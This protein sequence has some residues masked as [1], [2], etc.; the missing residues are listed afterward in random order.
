MLPVHAGPRLG[1][2]DRLEATGPGSH[3]G[4][5]DLGIAG[6]IAAAQEMVRDSG[7]GSQKAGDGWWHRLSSVLKSVIL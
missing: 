4:S 3:R 2:C 5:S 7:D 6:M 1:R